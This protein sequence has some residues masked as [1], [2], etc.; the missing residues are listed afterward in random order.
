MNLFIIAYVKCGFPNGST[1]YLM[2]GVRVAV[3]RGVS[4][5][6]G[7]DKWF[8]NLRTAP[9]KSLTITTRRVANVHYLMV[10]RYINMKIRTNTHT[11]RNT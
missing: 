8:V 11:P 2:V 7:R 9:Q 6:K 4:K 5:R 3:V 10:A 1:V